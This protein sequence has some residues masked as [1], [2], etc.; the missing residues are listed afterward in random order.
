[1]VASAAMACACL[2]LGYWFGGGLSA[3]RTLL[4]ILVPLGC[5]WYPEMMDRAVPAPLLR[6]A[7]WLV[8]VVILG[9]RVFLLCV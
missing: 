4:S 1:M 2:L 9:Y 5:I 6:G 8:L 7:A 3:A